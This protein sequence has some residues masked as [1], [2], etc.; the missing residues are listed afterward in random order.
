M[1]HAR[2][3][4]RPTRSS[5]RRASI[6]VDIAD[7]QRS[8][9]VGRRWLERLVRR[10]LAC[11]GIDAGEIA[12]VLVDDRRMAGLHDRWLGEKGPTDVI[13]F[14]LSAGGPAGRLQGDI[15]VSTET[16][17]RRSR[18]FG[19]PPRLEL[20]YYVIHGLLHL[21]GYDD[22]EPGD[23]RAMRLRERAVMKAVGLPPPPRRRKDS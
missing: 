17:Q 15:V 12:V 1:A 19:W 8:L 16:A 10:T 2:G 5:R 9:R 23:R 6:T 11:E 14:D 7:R 21:S 4:S 22:R 20:A 3:G 13:T 18:D